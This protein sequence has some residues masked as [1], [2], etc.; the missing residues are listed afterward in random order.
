MVTGSAS[1]LLELEVMRNM[2]KLIESTAF[3]YIFPSIATIGFFSNTVGCIAMLKRA[4]TKSTYNYLTGITIADSW[5][6]IVF[7]F[8]NFLPKNS[9]TLAIGCNFMLGS[10]YLFSTSSNWFLVLCCAERALMMAFPLK[11][12]NWFS[13]RRAR[14][15]MLIIILGSVH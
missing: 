7:A 14:L 15:V 5:F 8:W 1:D 4:R 10:M 2:Y 13:P 12:E 6:L 11:V 9:T 3:S